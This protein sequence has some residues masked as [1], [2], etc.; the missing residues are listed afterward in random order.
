MQRKTQDLEKTKKV[1]ADLPGFESLKALRLLRAT[2]PKRYWTYILMTSVG[3]AGL[4]ST[5][6]L[7]VSSLTGWPFGMVVA[8][9]IILRY[10]FT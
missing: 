3:F 1:L 9:L 6:A 7:I 8:L 4:V 2:S 5:A 10:I